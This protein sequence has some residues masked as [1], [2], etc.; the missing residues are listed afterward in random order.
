MKKIWFV[1]GAIA[2]VVAASVNA[3]SPAVRVAHDAIVID[4][5]AEVGGERDLPRDLLRRIVEEDIELMRMARAD[6]TYE[7]ATWQRLE[8]SRVTAQFSIQPREDRMETVEVRGTNVYRAIIGVASR[9]LLFRSNRPVWVERVDVEYVGEGSPDTR[10]TSIDVKSWIQPGQLRTVDLPVMARRATVRVVATAD[11]KA[12]YGN[13]DVALVQARLTDDADSPF[14]GAVEAAKAILRALEY[15]DVPSVRAMAQRMGESVGAPAG[16]VVTA[17]APRS[18][19][20]ARAGL[21]A[22]LEAIERLIS[23]TEAQRTEARERLRRVAQEL[24]P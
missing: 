17:V 10:Q 8:A 23:G 1:A 20:A 16:S 24:R 4:R 13:L 11:A 21:A 5:V 6:G 3:E 15:N 7:H 22:E 19:D 2:L 12:G 18:P 14:A 9:R